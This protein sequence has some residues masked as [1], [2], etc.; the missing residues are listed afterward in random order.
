M[1]HQFVLDIN[2]ARGTHR[3]NPFRLA[4]HGINYSS[5]TEEK[6]VQK[7]VSLKIIS[8]FYNFIYL[9]VVFFENCETQDFNV[10][11]LK[12][13]Q[14][15]AKISRFLGSSGIWNVH[16]LMTKYQLIKPSRGPYSWNIGHCHFLLSKSHAMYRNC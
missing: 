1:H 7:W 14:I 12:C 16:A 10:F 15:Y 4:F 13:F 2:N 6:L 3:K 5:D 11:L 9:N 8:S